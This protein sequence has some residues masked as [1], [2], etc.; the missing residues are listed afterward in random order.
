M[1]LPTRLTSTPLHKSRT[2]QVRGQV[3]V[4]AFYS[5]RRHGGGAPLCPR[6][7]E[8]IATEPLLASLPYAWRASPIERRDR[9]SSERHRPSIHSDQTGKAIWPACVGRHSLDNKR[10][11]PSRSMV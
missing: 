11:A 2:R 7:R 10:T 9:H 8:S 1:K 5:H 6:V 3:W 4:R